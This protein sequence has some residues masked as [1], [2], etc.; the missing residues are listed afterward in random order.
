MKVAIYT[1]YLDTSGG[2]EKYMLTIAEF[3]SAKETVDV[4]LDKH[5]AALDKNEVI[6]RNQSLHKLDLSKV[7]FIKAPIGVGSSFK[8]RNAFL[9]NYDL[10]FYNS[11]GSIFFSTAKRSVVHF[12]MPFDNKGVKGLWGIVKVKSWKEAIYNSEFTKSYIEKFWPIKGRVIYPPV[13]IKLFKAKKK[14]KQILSVGRF[15]KFK[16]HDLMINVFKE[17]VSENKL[18]DLSL[19][20]AGGLS[21]GDIVDLEALKKSAKG[22]KV[23]FHPDIP[24]EKL[25]I[26][27]GESLIYWHAAGFGEESLQKMEHFGISTVEAMAAGC[28]PVVVNLGGQ[29]EIV[30]NGKSGYLWGGIEEWKEQT[31]TVLNNKDL[32]KEF[33]YEAVLRSR[34]FSKERFCNNVKELVYGNN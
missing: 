3:L 12:Q 8:D 25:K 7:N 28:V 10:L 4:L 19:H 6:K 16:K 30:E 22:F 18:N 24:L 21:T 2:G 20:L 31:I 17:L 34:L 33:S 32:Q 29:R 9:K 23:F 26:L 11:D 1:P 14:K 27:Y 15:S 13:S 5:L